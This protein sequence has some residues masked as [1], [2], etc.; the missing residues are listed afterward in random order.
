VVVPVWLDIAA[1]SRFLDNVISKPFPKQLPFYLFF[2]YN[3]AS[4]FRLGE[5]S[6]GSVTLRSQLVPS[7]QKAATR[8]VGFNDTHVGI[9]NSEAARD[10]FLSLLDAVSLPRNTEGIGQ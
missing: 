10:S 2:S 1:P 4:L 7:L 5:S 3:D 8:V 9:L 6:D